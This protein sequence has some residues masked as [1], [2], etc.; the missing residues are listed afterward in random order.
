M[1]FLRRLALNVV[2]E[3]AGAEAWLLVF[4]ALVLT[5]NDGRLHQGLSRMR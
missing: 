4:R 3:E 1:L 5:G 2:L